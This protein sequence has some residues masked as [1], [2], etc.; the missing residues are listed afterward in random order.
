M[1]PT[2]PFYRKTRKRFEIPGQAR[3]LT[4]YCFRRQPFLS[5]RHSPEWLAEAIESARHNHP[6]Q[7]WAYVF[8]PE[9][10][11]MLIQP[12]PGVKVSAIL[13]DLKPRVTVK[14]LRWVR[15]Y[16]PSFLKRMTDRQPNG[17]CFHRFWQRGGGYD[18]NTWTLDELYEK[19]EYIQANPVRRGMV[20]H[21]RD[22]V[23]SRWHAWHEDVA[24]PGARG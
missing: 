12:E 24:G 8:L 10:M 21:P 22:W 17:D 9:Q 18:R 3:Y 19:I 6:F 23:W 5:S 20:E 16:K 2:Q 7:L 4:C 13:R 11:H 14:V 15:R 1:G